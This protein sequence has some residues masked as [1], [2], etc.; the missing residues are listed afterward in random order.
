MQVQVQKVP[1]ARCAWYTRTA[2]HRDRIAPPCR[3]VY[4]IDRSLR[5]LLL[6][7]YACEISRFSPRD[8]KLF[9]PGSVWAARISVFP[10]IALKLSISSR[11]L[12]YIQYFLLLDSS[13]L[14]PKPASSQ[15]QAS[16]T[17]P[18]LTFASH[19]CL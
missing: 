15:L 2:S 9:F 4:L 11:L 16:S 5:Y 7:P 19:I 10:D 1:H 13:N 8:L 18:A 14:H 6:R 3:D 17:L 12:G